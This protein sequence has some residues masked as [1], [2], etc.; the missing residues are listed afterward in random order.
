M[1]RFAAAL[2]IFLSGCGNSGGNSGAPDNHGYGWQYDAAGRNGLKLRLTGAMPENAESAEDRARAVGTCSNL[3]APPPPFVI[4]VPKGSLGP[5]VVGLYLR[6][7]PLILLDHDSGDFVYDHE[8]LHY[9]LDY[10]FGNPDSSH[11]R[12]EWHCVSSATIT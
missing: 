9:L 7:P 2:L 6:D 4:V 10:N 5:N 12:P 3:S 8:A 1:Y 11:Q